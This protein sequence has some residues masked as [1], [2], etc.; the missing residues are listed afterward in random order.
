MSP[1]LQIP[2]LLRESPHSAPLGF[3]ISG[4]LHEKLANKRTP[5][6]LSNPQNF[7]YELSHLRVMALGLGSAAPTDQPCV[8]LGAVALPCEPSKAS[9]AEE[10]KTVP[11]RPNARAE[12]HTAGAERSEGPRMCP[13]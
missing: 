3:S 13:L 4:E 2:K 7:S 10:W 12:R 8:S 9:R 1:P 11:P 5:K 6:H